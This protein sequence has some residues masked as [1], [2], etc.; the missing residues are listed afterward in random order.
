MSLTGTPGGVSQFDRDFF[1]PEQRYQSIGTGALGGKAAGLA[2]A[3][4][5]LST[6][7]DQSSFRRI[8]VSIPSLTVLRTDVFADFVRRNRLDKAVRP[9]DPDDAIA[10][11]FQ[12]GDLP[13]AIV[14]DLRALIEKV[15]TPLAIRSSSLLED[16]LSQPFAGVYRTKM[17]PNN[18]SSVDERFRRLVEAI[19][20][21]W[22]S[23]WFSDA[24]A[25]VAATG[26]AAQRD[27]MAVII[28]EVVGTRFRDRYYPHVSGVARSYSY[29]R[30][31]HAAPE[32]GVA[33]LALGLGKTIVDGGVCWTYSPAW[34]AAPAP[35]ASA[36]ALVKGTQSDFWAVNMGK[37]PAYDPIQEAEYLVLG[38]FPDAEEDG[39]LT[40]IASTWDPE[41]GRIR[42]GIGTQGPRV[43]DF[44]MLLSLPDVP[45]NDVVKALLPLFEKELGAPVEIEFAVTFDPNR[46]GF[47]QVRPMNVSAEAVTVADSELRSENALVASDSVMGNGVISTIRD[48]VYV[49]PASGPLDTRAI[50]VEIEAMN[51]ALVTRGRPYIA[52]GVGRWGSSD[53]SLGIPVV[54]SQIAGAKVI[55]E[56]MTEAMNVEL[57]QGSHFFHNLSSFRVPYFSVPL[58]RRGAIDWG[59]LERQK[60]VAER[61]HV[62]HVEAD[63]PLEIRV[64]GRTGRGVILKPEERS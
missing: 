44:A 45:V 63:R 12:R 23:T 61:G 20:L 53:P 16:D 7:F 39:T 52:I 31:G 9:D 33:S 28:Q 48:I 15:H 41:S 29:Y 55:V 27:Q 14:G 43:L 36:A 1:D 21:V 47:L 58:G 49:R 50:A 57:S 56:V 19:K 26:R 40:T 25:Y 51:A 4:R 32:D 35:F 22:A 62:R 17:I 5:I 30:A 54:W 46:F 2:T 24:R 3:H 13:P 8:E 6:A 60:L 59:W 34:P 18:Q 38:S 11:A 37:P 10:R 64:D 42:M